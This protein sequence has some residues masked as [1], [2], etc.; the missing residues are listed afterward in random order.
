MKADISSVVVVT[1][2]SE[3]QKQAEKLGAKVIWN[4]L[5]QEGNCLFYETGASGGL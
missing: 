3:I 2:Y 1:Q 4:P 5:P